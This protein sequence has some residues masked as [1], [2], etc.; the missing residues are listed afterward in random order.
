MEDEVL[1]V[2]RVDLREEHPVADDPQNSVHQ[3]QIQE[4]DPYLIDLPQTT[5]E[6]LRMMGY[7]FEDSI[8]EYPDGPDL[9]YPV[10]TSQ[11]TAM[12]S[13]LLPVLDL[14]PGSPD[15][16]LLPPLPHK[17]SGLLQIPL[18]KVGAEV[19][20]RLKLRKGPAAHRK[21]KRGSGQGPR[22]S[23][24]RFWCPP[25]CWAAHEA[26][27]LHHLDWHTVVVLKAPDW[28]TF[29]RWW[30][31]TAILTRMDR[32][33]RAPYYIGSLA[34]Q[35]T[36]GVIHCHLVIGGGHRERVLEILERWPE[37][38]REIKACYAPFGAIHY[39]LAQS[40]VP[41]IRGEA[42]RDYWQRV[43]RHHQRYPADDAILQTIDS[44]D[45]LLLAQRLLKAQIDRT[46]GRRAA[47][48]TPLTRRQEIARL[49]GLA[50]AA[51]ARAA[52]PDRHRKA[53]SRL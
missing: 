13:G 53:S 21:Y 15:G 34:I 25:E 32:L 47:A 51:K 43:K 49:G 10:K 35:P 27:R 16:V 45:N 36:K 19:Q 22:S 18:G 24:R 5:N 14:R 38:W 52:A 39:A 30:G 29:G 4:P 1:V 6:I 31:R 26:E 40:V 50:K 17:R 41:K 37:S 3:D 12:R 20:R 44:G 2:D 9:T 8:V 28:V 7:L 46:N 33:R 23:R 42:T 11:E 48:G